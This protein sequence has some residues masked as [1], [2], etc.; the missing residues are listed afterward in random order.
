MMGRAGGEMR[1]YLRDVTDAYTT[2]IGYLAADSGVD[3]PYRIFTRTSFHVSSSLISNLALGGKS[4]FKKPIPM[5][6]LK[7]ISPISIS[8]SHLP[9]TIRYNIQLPTSYRST[10]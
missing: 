7:Y 9:P 8:R 2:S 5:Y 1:S 4:Y 10:P 3:R 6:R